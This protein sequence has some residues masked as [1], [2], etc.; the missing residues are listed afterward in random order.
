MA[1]L[2]SLRICD[3]ISITQSLIKQNDS[4]MIIVNLLFPQASFQ[5]VSK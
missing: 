2:A 5:S 4:T 1:T 3:V